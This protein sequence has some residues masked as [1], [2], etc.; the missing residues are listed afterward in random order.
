VSAEQSEPTRAATVGEV[1]AALTRELTQRF[2][3][4]GCAVSRPVGDVLLLFAEHTRS[5]RSLQLGHGY[6][7][8]DYPETARVLATGTPLTVSAL[9]LD[10]DPA[11]RY[12]LDELGAT[13]VLLLALRPGG[14]TWGLVEIYRDGGATFSAD[15]E[16]R[17][18]AIV[19]TAA[20][21][22]ERS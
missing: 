13:A 2:D 10:A 3:A 15:E 16:R 7:V 6:L 20:A 4:L 9:D 22:L 14:T 18:E 1:L 8:T 12:V 11:E 17:A 21:L 19:A 5:G